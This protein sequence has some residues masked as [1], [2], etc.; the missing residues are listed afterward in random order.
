MKKWPILLFCAGGQ[1]VCFDVVVVAK[2][3]RLG[4]DYIRYSEVRT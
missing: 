1:S 2:V 3:F 4:S